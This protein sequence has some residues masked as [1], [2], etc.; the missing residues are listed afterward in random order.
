MSII[1][2]RKITCKPNLL[3][4]EDC[5]KL[6]TKRLL[7]YYKRYRYLRHIMQCDCCGELLYEGD[8]EKNEM[9]NKY[10]DSIKS[11]LNRRENVE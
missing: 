4:I 7:S 6:N 3:S 5:K 10:L 2:L 8:R 9:V 1:E 11:V